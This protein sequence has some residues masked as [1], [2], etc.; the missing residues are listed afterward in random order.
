[1][2]VLYALTLVFLLPVIWI[3]G[4]YRLF[5]A[6]DTP[7]VVSDFAVTIMHCTFSELLNL[8]VTIS[9]IWRMLYLRRYITDALGPDHAKMYTSVSAM[10]VESGA[11]FSVLMLICNVQLRRKLG[12]GFES[13]VYAI[14]GQATASLS[15]LK[16]PRRAS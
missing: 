8:A 9:I 5:Q 3:V 7:R 4:L 6:V 1:M 14:M 12:L 16:S 15:L 13:V 2:A 11:I 10:F